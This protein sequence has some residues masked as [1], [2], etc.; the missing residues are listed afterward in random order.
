MYCIGHSRK[1]QL[2]LSFLFSE[3]RYIELFLNSTQSENRMG[4]GYSSGMGGGGGGGFGSGSGIMSGNSMGGGSYSNDGSYGGG[5]GG[6]FGTGGGGGTSGAGTGG[7][8]N[9]G[10]APTF[11]YYCTAGSSLCQC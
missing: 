4:G 10:W 3:H 7:G 6:N 9:Q 2:S 5:S 8:F 11:I 1:V